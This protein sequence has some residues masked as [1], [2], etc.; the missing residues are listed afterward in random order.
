[1]YLFLYK[2]KPCTLYK[3]L[4]QVDIKRQ[5]LD[6]SKFKVFADNN[7][8][9]DENGRKY[10]RGLE[11]TVGKGEIL[12]DLWYRHVK[13]KGLF[14]KGQILRLV[15][16]QS[17]CRRQVRFDSDDFNLNWYG[18]K[19]C[20]KRRKPPFQMALN[21]KSSPKRVFYSFFTLYQMIPNFR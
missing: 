8:K 13:I 11:N 4:S 12:K 15:E 1:M 20:E 3:T 19:H 5:I 14:G 10:S 18:R 17:I 9:L 16:T 2:I 21:G 6:C 7:F